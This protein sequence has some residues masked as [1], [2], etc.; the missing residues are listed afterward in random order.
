MQTHATAYTCSMHA[1]MHDEVSCQLGDMPT[2]QTPCRTRPMSAFPPSTKT[3]QEFGFTS[4]KQ[5]NLWAAKQ[6]PYPHVRW[7]KA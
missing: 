7:A 6:T 3:A 5:Q 2:M 1:R 4:T